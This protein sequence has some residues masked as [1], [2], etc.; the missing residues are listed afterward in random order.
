MD[1]RIVCART[2]AAAFVT[3][4][5]SRQSASEV[6]GANCVP[7]RIYIH[8]KCVHSLLRSSPRVL[9]SM[10]TRRLIG[11][12]RVLHTH[13][14]LSTSSRSASRIAILA[15]ERP[16]VPYYPLALQQVLW[17]K[18][19][20]YPGALQHFAED[21]YRSS[22]QIPPSHSALF[23][24]KS[25]PCVSIGYSHR[26]DLQVQ[27]AVTPEGKVPAVRRLAEGPVIFHDEDS[28]NFALFSS[29]PILDWSMQLLLQALGSM[30]P[31]T[32]TP[33]QLLYMHLTIMSSHS[34]N[35][36]AL[37]EQGTL[38]V[39]ACRKRLD[40]QHHTLNTSTLSTALMNLFGPQRIHEV[41][42]SESHNALAR[43]FEDP[44]FDQRVEGM[45][46]YIR[47]VQ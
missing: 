7:V 8:I 27:K 36:G 16:A 11:G 6:D 41:N 30:C 37:F 15:T 39:R 4:S 18:Y 34:T 29:V 19:R 46:R 1:R 9:Y 47:A 31:P 23:L 38:D 28:L 14:S 25:A 40:I 20:G 35:T 32:H 24:W 17:D 43:E 13:A 12:P 45:V 2:A 26:R 44:E 33:A 10:I 21:K 42:S 22:T 3:G 5:L